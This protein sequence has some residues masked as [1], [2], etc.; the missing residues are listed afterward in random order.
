MN[1]FAIPNRRLLAKKVLVGLRPP[2]DLVAKQNGFCE[3]RPAEGGA[4]NH[5]V[6]KNR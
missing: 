4:S 2:F 5:F 6:L 3:A 1:C